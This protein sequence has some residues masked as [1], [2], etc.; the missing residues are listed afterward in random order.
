MTPSPATTLRPATRPEDIFDAWVFA[1][2]DAT[3]ALR[4]WIAALPRDR[5][6]AHAVYRAA[7]D[8]EESAAVALKAASR[9]RRR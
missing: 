3:E 4:A 8:R 1:A 2:H 9:R 6:A 7:L 5:A